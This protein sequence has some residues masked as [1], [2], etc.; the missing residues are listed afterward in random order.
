MLVKRNYISLGMGMLL[1][2][3]LCPLVYAHGMTEAE[4]LIIMEGGNLGYMEIG[5]THMLTGYDHLLFVFGVIFF[6]RTFRDIVKYVT[7]FTLGHSV[8][9]IFATLNAIQINYFL[10][11]AVIGLSV[12]YIAFANI[13]GFRRYLDIKPPNML[14]M[15]TC[16]GLIHGLGLS[17]RLQELPLSE[18]SLLLNIISFNVG[19]ELGQIFALLLMIL[20]IDI[21]RKTESF[22]KFSLVSNYLLIC[23]GVLLFLM[24][25]HGYTHLSDPLQFAVASTQV[26]GGVN[27]TDTV[28]IAA[29]TGS[30]IQWKDTINITIPANGSKEYKFQMLENGV[31][32]YA[33][34]T[35]IEKLFYEFHGEPKGDTTG[36]FK[37]YE[38]NTADQATG[39]LNAPFEGIH[40]WYWQN[41][42]LSP[43]NIVLNVK[44]EYKR[45]D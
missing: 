28:T 34:K 44:G 41:N 30:R 6:L 14:V 9:L 2:T 13:E 39:I 40:G 29:S 10:I 16:L 20:A 3:L 5:A 23:A 42:T 17:S 11:D 26:Q 43:V 31:L 19:I 37:S 7:A 1:Y 32:E 15:I 8:T 36:Y 27:G 33:W 35:D 38:K 12:S 18:D 25:M 4:K 24:Q 22:Q 21:W 45:L